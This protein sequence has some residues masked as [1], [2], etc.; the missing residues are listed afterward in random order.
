MAE[1]RAEAAAA[2]IDCGADPTGSLTSIFVGMVQAGRIARGQCP[3]QRPVFL[4]PHGV[5]HGRLVVRPDLEPGLR[6]GILAGTGYPAWVRFSSDTV[7]TAADFRTTVGIGVKLFGVPGA[8]LA[9][10]PGDTTADL[11]MQNHDRFFVDTAAEM[12][13]FTR[14]GVV[15]GDYGPYL[16]AHALTATILDEMAK[17]VASALAESYW[18]ILPSRLGPDRHVKYRLEPGIAADPLA[19]APADP[20]YLAADLRA[21]LAAGE[22]RFALAIQLRADPAT[23]PLDAATVRWDESAAPWV[24]V[25]DLVLD[26]Q[27]VDARGQ[28]DY[29]ENLAMNIW[30]VPAEHEPVGSIAE[31]RRVVYSASADARRNVNGVPAGEP[32]A[33]RTPTAPPP[34]RDTRVVSAR[35]HPGIGIA[36]IGDSATDFIVGP[37]VVGAPPGPAGGLR[38]A[39]GALKRQAA[40][41]RIYGLNAAGEVVRELA[42][43]DAKIEWTAHLANKK[44]SWYRFLAALD[45]PEAVAMKCPRRNATVRGAARRDLEIDPGPRTI[46]GADAG[47]GAAHAFD[48]GTFKGTAV[49][50]GALRTDEAGR[51]LVLGGT[52]RSETPSGAPIFVQ[53]DGDSFNNGDD[54][55]DDVSDGPVTAKVSIG[56]RDI[57]V[58]GAWVAVAPPNYAPDV[59]G[60]RTLHDLLV[61]TYVEAGWLPV[62]VTVSFSDHVLPIVTRL[63]NL[64]WVNKG[65]AA[66]FGHGGPLDFADARLIAKLATPRDA[67]SGRD[68]HAE[69]RARIAG[70]FRPQD[71]AVDEP[72]TWPWIYGDAF[73]IEGNTSARN[74]L[75]LGSLQT[76]ILARWVEGDFAATGTRR[77]RSR[78]PSTTCPLPTGPRCSTARRS[79]TV[80]PTPSIPA[81]S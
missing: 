21:R 62:P 13:A 75:A 65:F 57:P 23:M 58:A 19:S 51:L 63:S 20:A 67:A 56:G 11:I 66:M 43:A 14:A 45:I 10:A 24:Q 81:A 18:S 26:R 55:F 5:A 39:G 6:V 68:P 69:L 35:I 64:Q 44:A 60:W 38:D 70:A 42:A 22:A 34:A 8:K 40:R 79:T 1:G 30:R 25:A 54:W 80:S 53:S 31:A 73:G 28:A 74:S 2:A 17:P 37:E 76:T 9:G 27:D 36:R 47:G 4:K 46:A 32:N 77:A 3:A 71:A 29:G 48:T 52:G 59:V 33:P 15:G 41:F 49:S 12:C 16:A 78:P 72:R 50:L 61:E 7:P